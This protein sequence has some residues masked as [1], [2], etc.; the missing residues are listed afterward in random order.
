MTWS[1]HPLFNNN[2]Q[3]NITYLIEVGSGEYICIDPYQGDLVAEWLDKRSA[4]LSVVINTHEHWDH[5]GGNEE[6]RNYYACEVWAHSGAAE[7][8][9]AVD[10]KLEESEDLFMQSGNKLTVL[11][12]P[13]HTAGHLS[14]VHSKAERTLALFS[15]DTIFNGGVGNCKNGGNPEVLFE[16]VKR[17]GNILSD[18]CILYPGHDYLQ[19]NL[20]FSKSLVPQLNFS[21]E[22]EFKTFKQE[23]EY[24]L[25]LNLNDPLIAQSLQKQGASEKEIFL[26]LRRRRDHW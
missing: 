6:L 3:A 22:G 13:G 24:N 14:L 10:R 9:G 5:I 4:W 15:G 17:L 12:T 20:A 1:I 7:K 25:F 16:S 18:D 26:E 19:N 11:H 21:P 2:S 8:I 23:R